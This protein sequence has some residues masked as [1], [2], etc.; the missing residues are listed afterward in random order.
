MRQAFSLLILAL[1]LTSCASVPT[2]SRARLEDD[3]REAVFRYQFAEWKRPGA[4][5]FYLDVSGG[6]TDPS[7]AFLKRFAKV[8]PTVKKCSKGK[9]NYLGAGVTD[10]DTG[11][12]GIIFRAGSVAWVTSTEVTVSGGFYENGQSASGDSYIVS[13]FDGRWHV[14]ADRHEWIARADYLELNPQL[15]SI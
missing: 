10:A 13:F 3:I 9:V 4:G 8:Q 5:A 6:D 7:D 11:K 15:C 14:I 1:L 2:A 12:P